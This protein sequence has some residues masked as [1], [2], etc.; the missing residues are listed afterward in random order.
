[1]PRFAANLSL[2]FTEMPYLERFQAASDAGFTAVEVLFPYDIAAT[3]TRRALL[4]NGLELVLINA[5]PP[6]YTGGAPGYAAIPDGQ[7]RFQSDIRRVLRYAGVLRP[8][9]IHIMSGYATGPDAL[10]CF[11]QNLQWAADF[12]PQQQFTIE[13]LN[14]VSQ[15]GYFLNDYDLAA[16]V[17]NQVNRPNVGLQY[18]SFHAHMIH[19]DALAVWDRFH[20]QVVH[21][22]VGA[23]P[24]RTEPGRGPTDFKALFSAMDAAGYS[25]WISAEYTPSIQRTCDTLDWMRDL[26]W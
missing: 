2:L 21:T 19:G 7:S 6:N 24:D 1:M 23:A 14:P 5:P 10:S 4:A 11:V 15:P 17:L 26:H 16:E 12:A 20:P 13:P 9:L 3:E 22:Q 8:G 18:D 25:G